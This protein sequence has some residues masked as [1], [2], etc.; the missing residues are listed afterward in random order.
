RGRS[1]IGK[2]VDHVILGDLAPTE[3]AAIM[4][5]LRDEMHEASTELRFEDAA[6]IRDQIAELEAELLPSP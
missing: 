6:S 2:G 5:Q 3:V 1:G 4:Q